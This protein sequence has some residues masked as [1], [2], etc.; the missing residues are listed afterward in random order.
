MYNKTRMIER[1]ART[2]APR[3]IKRDTPGLRSYGN[4][5]T[6]CWLRQP[7]A[8][9]ERA[10]RWICH[11]RTA[12]L[13]FTAVLDFWFCYHRSVYAMVSPHIV[14]AVS[15][16]CARF[17]RALLAR[18]SSHTGLRY[19]FSFQV[20]LPGC[21]HCMYLLAHGFSSSCRSSGFAIALDSGCLVCWLDM[22]YHKHFSTFFNMVPG[23]F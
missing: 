16:C 20:S 5:F 2:R 17:M 13:V 14:S 10:S 1:Y 22:T 15:C 21:L 23:L 11:H 6:C 7:R 12:P 18:S 19:A 3:C 4:L 8:T 9:N